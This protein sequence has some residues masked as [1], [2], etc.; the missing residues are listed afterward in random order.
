MSKTF[1]LLLLLC[2][3]V[4]SETEYEFEVIEE[5]IPKTFFSDGSHKIFK[6][7]LSCK[8]DRKETNIYFQAMT[9]DYFF[10]YLYDNLTKIQ[11]D[12]HEN[13]KDYTSRKM[14][15]TN[16]NSIP[17]NNL[18]CN[19][20]YYFIILK[21][22][23]YIEGNY[24]CQF[25][26]I[27]DETN[28]FNLSPSLSLYFTLFPRNRTES[29]YYSF[30]KTK[31]A[32]INYDG[33]IEIEED[34]KI[35]YNNNN[36]NSKIF[37]FKKDLKYNI[38]YISY[39]PIHIH[40]YNESNFFKYNKE[41]FP[42][43]LYGV[44]NEYQF[45]INISDYKEG[46]NI[47]LK[48]YANAKWY[49]KYQ[50][51]N[52]FKSNKFF[53]LEEYEDLNYIPIKKI[54][55]ESS[56]ILYIKY[57]KYYNS[58]SILDIVKDEVIEIKSDINSTFT[59]PK[60]LFFDYFKFNKLNSFAI[61]TNKNLIIYEQIMDSRM[62]MDNIYYKNIYIYKQKEENSLM[63][64]RGFLILNST[65]KYKIVIKRFNFSII[66]K[67]QRDRHG[68]EYISL[69]QGEDPKTEFYYYKDYHFSFSSKIFELFTPVFGNYESSFINYQD[70]K[71]LSDF[72]FSN[73]NKTKVYSPEYEEGYIKISCKEP[74]LIK[75]SFIDLYYIR[76]SYNLTS[77]KSYI[78]LL[79]YSTKETVYLSDT[80]KGKKVSLKFSVLEPKI[81]YQIQLNLNGTNHTLLANMSLEFEFE[82]T[83][84][85]EGTYFIIL[86]KGKIDDYIFIEI[87]VGNM[88]NLK[89]L[90]IINLNDAFENLNFGNKK[91]VIIKVPKENDDNYYNFSIIQ[92]RFELY[93]YY[94]EICYDKIEFIPINNSNVIIREYSHFI[95]F[96]A[97][98]YS[99]I[100]K[101]REKSDEKY[102]YIFIYYYRYVGDNFLIKRPKLFTDINL[103]TINTF[104]QLNEE[105][106]QYYYKIPFPNEDYD[107][108]TIQ[109]NY[110]SNITLSLSKENTA[111]LFEYSSLNKI[112]KDILNKNTYLNYYGNS[113]SDGYINFISGNELAFYQCYESF[114]FNLTIKQKEKTNKL[115]INL[116]SYSYHIKRPIIYY[117]IIFN[118][119]QYNYNDAIIYPALTEKRNFEKYKMMLKNEDNG[120]NEYFQTELEIKINLYDYEIDDTSNEMIIVPVDKETNF[121]FKSSID[122][123]YFQYKNLKSNTTTILIIIIVIGI[124]VV[125]IIIGL[126]Y[127]R[128][129]KKEKSNNIE[130]IMDINE[131]I[132]SDN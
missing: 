45:E 131:K 114:Q 29:F 103:N 130:E 108:L 54:K 23:T 24:Y 83:Y 106:K 52:D 91:S 30:D 35:I 21:D 69:C 18:T 87:V 43:M 62:H 15:S 34:G 28:K 110:N 58:L 90:E 76:Y 113:Y 124:L 44:N 80:L 7:N 74:T 111:Y 102:F 42:M 5:F 65:D 92:N 47:I 81:N 99:Y 10:L 51:K 122:S 41:D 121:I 25:S 75:L 71:T 82:Y 98:P 118:E 48:T 123:K 128:K 119:F 125:I 109:I 59:G 127:Y 49:I 19:K 117:F 84:Q 88:D 8:D 96:S 60:F 115:I 9:N 40:F 116:N 104:P 4:K 73:P 120:E 77:G 126:L 70:I 1:V 95:S 100:P 64:K 68:H 38:K 2:Y 67:E 85:E 105:D 86:D 79:S 61:E 50:Y 22:S 3:S 107:S 132:L 78:Y 63:F 89:E 94:V 31:Y 33:I 27:N 72:D 20:V 14:I 12:E 129:K 66:E 101:N 37:E 11:K 112:P 57:K 26:I 97:N 6:Y 55:N 39:S 46:E 32:L 56:L 13:Y 36:T 53:N 17:L 93:Y 16:E